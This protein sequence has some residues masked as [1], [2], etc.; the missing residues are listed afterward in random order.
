MLTGGNSADTNKIPASSVAPSCKE[1][2]VWRWSTCFIVLGENTLMVL[3]EFGRSRSG[4]GISS[5][6]AQRERTTLEEVDFDSQALGATQ[7][8]ILPRG[9]GMHEIPHGCCGQRSFVYHF[10]VYKCTSIC[11]VILPAYTMPLWATVFPVIQLRKLRLNKACSRWGN[12]P[13]VELKQA[14]DAPFPNLTLPVCLVKIWEGLLGG[15]S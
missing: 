10:D 11:M 12:G 1:Y 4:W 15:D 6:T 13:L 9:L 2:W 3:Q 14:Q 5:V 7:V 8:W